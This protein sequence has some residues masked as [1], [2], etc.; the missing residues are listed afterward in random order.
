M[1]NNM[2]NTSVKNFSVVAFIN[3]EVEVILQLKS[4]LSGHDWKINILNITRE[5]NLS[6]LKE[7]LPFSNS[8]EIFSKNSIYK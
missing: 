2:I 6:G 1:N 5:S 3:I 4:L 8:R 7:T